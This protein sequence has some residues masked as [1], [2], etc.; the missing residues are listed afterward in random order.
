MT[1]NTNLPDPNLNNYSAQN[2]PGL[3]ISTDSFDIN[4]HKPNS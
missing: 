2:M 3:N 1:R 4:N